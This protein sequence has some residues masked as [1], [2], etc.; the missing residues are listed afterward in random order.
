MTKSRKPTASLLFNG[1][2]VTCPHFC[3]VPRF[4]GCSLLNRLYILADK[5]GHSPEASQKAEEMFKE[6]GEAFSV[7]SDAKKR[8]R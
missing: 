4:M 8:Q 3:L 6:V 7:L 5:H 2:L 1:T